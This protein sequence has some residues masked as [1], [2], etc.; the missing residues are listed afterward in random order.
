[1]ACTQGYHVFHK[2]CIKK[3]CYPENVTK[4]SRDHQMSLDDAQQAIIAEAVGNGYTPP[5]YNKCPIC[6][7]SL[8]CDSS[9]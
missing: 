9:I 3:Y 1:M 5:N 4:H 2:V 8:N 7:Q 6:K